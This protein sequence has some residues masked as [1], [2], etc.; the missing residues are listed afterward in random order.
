M[1]I[2][3][4]TLVAALALAAAGPLQ[5]A[6][7]EAG[8]AKAALCAACHG[9]AGIATTDI[10]PN[11]AGQNEKYLVDAINQYRNGKR[12][13]PMMK[14]MVAALSDADVENIAAFYAAQPC[15]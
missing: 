12:D 2:V 11:L 14:P 15:K 5:A 13:N 6:D 9:P 4:S 8:K 1:H 10:Y 7:A 3:K